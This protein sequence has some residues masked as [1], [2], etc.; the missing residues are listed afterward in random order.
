MRAIMMC[1][2]SIFLMP[3][4]GLAQDFSELPSRTKPGELLD[5]LAIDGEEMRGRVVAFTRDTLT[6]DVAG[7]HRTI[8]A[9]ETARIQ[10]RDS[11]R[12]GVWAGALAGAAVGITSGAVLYAICANEGGGCPGALA[13]ISATGTGVGAL[14]G[15]GLDG[16]Q[17]K[18]I[19]DTSRGVRFSNAITRELFGNWAWGHVTS[20]GSANP[21]MNTGIGWGAHFANGVG[22]EFD[23]TRSAGESRRPV[24]CVRLRFDVNSP[25][26]GEGTHTL[27]S[28]TVA[29]AKVS[30]AFLRTSRVQP[31]VTGGAGFAEYRLR[32]SIAIQP[33]RFGVFDP[34][35]PVSIVEEGF[36]DDGL[37][38]TFG[39]GMHVPLTRALALRTEVTVYPI[40]TAAQASM[41]RAAVGLGYRW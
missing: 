15:A 26:L 34:A 38:G 25:C 9:R 21:T 12:N 10:R 5:V 13:A 22:L 11:I 18:T 28:V 39:G 20:L 17:H 23:V 1:C 16:L 8:A 24:S 19:Y 40:A 14:I 35:R 27:E 31:F 6:L 30:Y 29:S 7:A 36:A 33:G 2:F 41:V 37:V 4:H 3:I 32:R